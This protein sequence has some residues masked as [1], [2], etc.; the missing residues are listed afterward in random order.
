MKLRAL[1]AAD[2]IMSVGYSYTSAANDAPLCG[3]KMN[4]IVWILVK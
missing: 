4:E 1:Y 3:R 2:N